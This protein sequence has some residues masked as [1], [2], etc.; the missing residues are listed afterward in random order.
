MQKVAALIA[1]AFASVAQAE[2]ASPIEK[3]IEMI[4]ELQAKVIGEG[5]DAQKIYDEFA[6]FCEDRSRELGFEIKTGKAQ[7]AELTATIDKQ[8]A[9]I[10]ALGAKIEEL[11]GSIASDEKDLKAATDVRTKEAA[12]FTS[13]DKELT[14][15]IETLERAIAII[16][17]EMAGGASFLQSKNMGNLAEA[18]AAMV[19]A[20][21][22]STA[23]GARLTALVQSSADDSDAEDGAPDAAVYESHSGGIVDT[24]QNL[25]EKGENQLSELRKKETS[26]KNNYEMLK[27]SLDDSIKFANED[28]AD[29]K[30]S[31]AECSEKKATAEGDL[32]ATQKDLAEDEKALSDLHHDCL[33][34]ATNFEEET[35]SRGEELAAIAEA[36]KI[37]KE[38]TG[39][40]ASQSYDLAQ[41]SLV[42]VNS[43]RSL[44]SAVVKFVRRLAQKQNSAMLA[45]LASRMASTVR[46]GGSSS[47]DVFAKVKGLINDMLVKLE[48]EA[49]EDANKK[50]FCDKETKETTAKK[51]EKQAEVDKLTTKIN[52]M[53]SESA[54]LKEEVATLQNELAELAKAQVNMDKVR[55]DEKNAYDKNRPELEQGVEGIKMAL[56]VLKD[57]Y[58]SSGKD[59]SGA[60]GI[61]GLLEVAESDFS[62]G[63]AEMIATEE[64]AA[65]SYEAETKENAIVK[66]TKEKDVEFKT[67]EAASL[68]KSVTEYS[69]D[70]DN[71][72]SELDAVLEYLDKINEQCVAKAETYE[73]R[74]ARREAEISGL[75]EAL[76]ILSSEAALLQKSAVR[77]TLRGGKLAF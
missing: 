41:V 51:D 19:Q 64:T 43:R 65:A 44:D 76:E 5:K 47:D 7:V 31:S 11:A 26:A 72:Q 17:R 28:M 40:A 32:S 55:A 4:S 45:Q 8:T 48:D 46:F 34:K 14:A 42:Q 49:K 12:D 61:I 69:S 73:E 33:T 13:E 35:K 68:D 10:D 71:V 21:A 3:I 24:L 30:K 15:T 29:A 1:F 18:F 66:V 54:Q 22:L 59:S 58:A 77:R 75:K 39:G 57:Y 74:T 20:S 37:I 2:E 67:K 52:Q 36:K 25:L 16:E 53:K 6:E 62:K 23:D 60:S 9:D 63:L 56:K 70:L 27:Q 50:A 38:T